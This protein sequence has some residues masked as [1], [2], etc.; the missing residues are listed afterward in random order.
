MVLGCWLDWE[1]GG[2]VGLGGGRPAWTG[3]RAAARLCVLGFEAGLRSCLRV[4]WAGFLQPCSACA[5]LCLHREGEE[6][7]REK[8]RKKAVLLTWQRFPVVKPGGY[9]RFGCQLSAESCCCCWLA[10]LH[11]PRAS[12]VLAQLT[13]PVRK[14]LTR[15]QPVNQTTAFLGTFEHLSHVEFPA[16][17]FNRLRGHLRRRSLQPVSGSS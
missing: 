13:Q 15:N 16:P 17:C 2:L 6:R 4:S 8:K 1:E 14:E 10:W 7:G 9:R 12:A 11:S 3:R 5:C